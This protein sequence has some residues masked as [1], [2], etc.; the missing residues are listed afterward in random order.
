MR[1]QGL[2]QVSKGPDWEGWVLD[3]AQLLGRGW[4][5]EGAEGLRFHLMPAI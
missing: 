2:G 4:D 1:D 3:G 5:L